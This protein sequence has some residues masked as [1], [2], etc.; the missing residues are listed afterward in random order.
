MVFN[1]PDLGLKP[2]NHRAW[3]DMIDADGDGTVTKDEMFNYFKSIS[4]HG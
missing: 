2:E 4:Y 3:F 1:R